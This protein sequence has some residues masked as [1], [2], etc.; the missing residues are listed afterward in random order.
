[1]SA[2][3]LVIAQQY[4]SV[5]LVSSR[6]NSRMEKFCARFKNVIPIF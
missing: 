3:P 2:P 5:T 6:F 4:S 1:M